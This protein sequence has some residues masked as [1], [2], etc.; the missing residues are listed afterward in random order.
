[1]IVDEQFWCY[2]DQISPLNV[3]VTKTKMRIMNQGERHQQINM[4]RLMRI[5]A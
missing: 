2:G 1:M 5:Y 4:I 3:N